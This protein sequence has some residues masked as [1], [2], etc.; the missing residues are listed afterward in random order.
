MLSDTAARAVPAF[1]VLVK[2]PSAAF[3]AM[4]AYNL[5]GRPLWFPIIIVPVL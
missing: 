5:Q 1:F 2:V 4:R 3:F